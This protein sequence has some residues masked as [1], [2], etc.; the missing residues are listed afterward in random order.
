M[1][2]RIGFV[3]RP[4]ALGLV[5][6]AVATAVLAAGVA[7]ARCDRVVA[8]CDDCTVCQRWLMVGDHLCYENY[9]YCINT[10]TGQVDGGY[11]ELRC[12]PF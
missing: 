12:E 3:R 7:F 8:G 10:C 1:K 11:N 6:A 5:L 4:A 9:Y 2:A